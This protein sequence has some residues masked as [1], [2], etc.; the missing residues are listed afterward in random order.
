MGEINKKTTMSG[1]AGAMVGHS[2][3]EAEQEYSGFFVQ[4]GKV[5]E[6]LREEEGSVTD[7]P[8]AGEYK[9]LRQN[10]PWGSRTVS[11]GPA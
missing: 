9:V 10:Q 11:E 3:T 5:E 2:V 6:L 8:V 4:T 1:M 7:K